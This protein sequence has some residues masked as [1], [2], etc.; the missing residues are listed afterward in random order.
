VGAGLAA[1]EAV[2]GL[3]TPTGPLS[4]RVGIATGP[5]V[6]GDVVGRGVARE[7]GVAGETPNVAARLQGLAEPGAVVLDGATRRLTGALFD[8]ADLGEVKLKGLPRPVRA[9]RAVHEGQVESRFEALRSGAAPP[10]LVGR[11]EELELLLGLWRRAR[12]GEGRVV[13]LGGE[14]GIGKSRLVAALRVALADRSNAHERLDW[15][16]APQHRGSALRPVITRL[17]RA[18]A[19]A[20]G[21]APEAKLAKLRALL[22][23]E[24]QTQEELGLVADLLGLRADG[25][26]PGAGLDARQRRERTLAALLRRVEAL[27]AR[28]PVLGVFEDAHWADPTTIELLDLVVGRAAGL[29]LLLVVTHR[30]EFRAPWA[31]Q[32]HVAEL[33]LDRLGPRDS[34]ALVGRVAA[35]AGAGA[36][37]PEVARRSSGAPTACRSSPRS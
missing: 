6:V 19:F 24:D 9:W 31:G 2:A 29:P 11:E 1:T 3:E 27:A 13:L 33:R 4:A 5:V 34:A 26:G 22:A 35:A 14:A 32:A 15:F 25:H 8:F 16:C 18:A 30:P 37:P 23:P 17:E 7:R 36:L 12:V 28:R 21:D 20:S 10:P